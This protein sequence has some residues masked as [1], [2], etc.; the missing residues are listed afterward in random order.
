[1]EDTSA[2]LNMVKDPLILSFLNFLKLNSI[3]QPISQI[4]APKPET[5]SS[6]TLKYFLNIAQNLPKFNL[7]INGE[8][9]K[10]QGE[11][12]PGIYEG[13]FKLWEC[14]KDGVD[15]FLENNISLHE[16]I[17]SHIPLYTK[18]NPDVLEIGCGSG[19]FGILCLLLDANSVT[20]QDFNAEVQVNIIFLKN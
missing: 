8:D 5:Q 4:A 6:I 11:I 2:F 1:M 16:F 15:Y 10:S 7:T 9:F 14:E 20:F 18:T 3:N 13:G 17:K 12:K 19:L